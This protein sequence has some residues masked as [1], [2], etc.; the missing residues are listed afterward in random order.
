[1]TSKSLLNSFGLHGTGGNKINN[2][3]LNIFFMQQCCQISFVITSR[4][5][6]LFC[7]GNSNQDFFLSIV[8]CKLSFIFME[9][10]STIW[11][12]L[13]T[14]VMFCFLCCGLFH[15]C[16]IFFL[17]DL[18]LTMYNTRICSRKVGLLLFSR[19]FG[20]SSRKKKIPRSFSRM[21]GLRDY[22]F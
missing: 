12:V 22:N 7:A 2:K 15:S 3:H 6:H 4:I 17:F 1:M 18:K 5:L 20:I 14:F 16:G 21:M 11:N 10:Y 8:C 13:N 19:I 9:Y